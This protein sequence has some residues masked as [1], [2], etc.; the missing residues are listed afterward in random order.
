MLL[1]V[2]DTECNE[3]IPLFIFIVPFPQQFNFNFYFNSIV[4][5][6]MRAH[7]C[8]LCI[9]LSHGLSPTMLLFVREQMNGNVF[10]R[11]ATGD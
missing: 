9:L 6:A 10:E 5:F 3:N 7:L 11:V 2:L 1:I 8:L 4:C